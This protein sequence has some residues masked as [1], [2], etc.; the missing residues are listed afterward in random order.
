MVPSSVPSVLGKRGHRGWEP[1]QCPCT[2]KR[3][4][5][6]AGA[7]HQPI[8]HRVS[9]VPGHFL[10]PHLRIV[11]RARLRRRG[12]RRAIIVIAFYFVV[13][14]VKSLGKL[15]VMFMTALVYALTLPFALLHH[16]VN[17]LRSPSRATATGSRRRFDPQA[18]MGPQSRS[19]SPRVQGLAQSNPWFPA[20]GGSPRAYRVSARRGIDHQTASNAARASSSNARSVAASVASSCSGRLAPTIAEVIP[21][22]CSTHA[23]LAVASLQ[24][25]RSQ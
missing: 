20:A 6:S 9:R 15:L 21:G 11:L 3:N 10:R 25:R 4:T 14:V 13:S 12:T 19:L 2:I 22:C 7:A 17:R 16:A 1:M 23:T 18:R 8:I 24:P 5:G